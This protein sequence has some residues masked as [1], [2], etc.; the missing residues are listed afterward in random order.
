MA[1]IVTKL[2]TILDNA[3]DEVTFY[4]E[5]DGSTYNVSQIRV[6][7]EEDEPDEVTLVADV[8]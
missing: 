3:D 6:V 1:S 2:Q 7:H 8:D 5:V 4:V